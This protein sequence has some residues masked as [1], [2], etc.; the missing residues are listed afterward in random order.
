MKLEIKE[1]ELLLG[2]EDSEVNLRH[3]LWN[4]NRRSGGIFEML[5]T[6]EEAEHVVAN[7]SG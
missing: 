1:L 3:I 2:P 7:A 5:N 4:A 6:K